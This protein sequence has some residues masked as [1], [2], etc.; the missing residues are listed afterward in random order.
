MFGV[1][2]V[3][4][5]LAYLNEGMAFIGLL[6]YA[7]AREAYG[8]LVT[9]LLY[10]TWDFLFGLSLIVAGMGVL[11]LKEWARVMWLGLMPALVLVHLGIIVANELFRNGASA[12]YLV[13]TAMVVGVAALSW[14]YF[15]ET[16]IRARFSPR[17]EQAT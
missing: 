13:W 9:Y 14:W 6:P 5:G 4:L 10:V 12:L 8:V 16:R 7:L 15:T 1:F 3:V 2:G 11:L 17:K